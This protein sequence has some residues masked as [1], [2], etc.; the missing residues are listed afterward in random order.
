M[1]RAGGWGG[2]GNSPVGPV[3]G[4]L[5]GTL[6][7]PVV[8]ALQ[9]NS[10]DPA[11][12][13]VVDAG[14][15]LQWDGT[16][17][18]A[19]AI[20]S[21]PTV[22]VYACPMSAVITDGVYVSG[23]LTVALADASTAAKMPAIGFIDGKPTATTCTIRAAGP[24]GGFVDSNGDPLVAGTRYFFDPAT[25]GRLKAE[26]P[27]PPGPTEQQGGIALSGGFLDIQLGVSPVEQ[28]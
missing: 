24:L 15:I 19:V 5:R 9:T 8:R 13:G 14:K 10:I 17:Y 25:P 18:V 4:D 16:K 23:D 26:A 7:N 28:L 3:G 2:G 27:T 12:L 6:P 1:P 11:V 22:Q 21:P 20:A